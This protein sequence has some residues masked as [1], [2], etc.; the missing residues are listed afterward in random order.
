MDG[1]ILF[2]YKLMEGKA[3]TRNAIKLLQI[4]G[5]EDAIIEDATRLAEHFVTF[6]TW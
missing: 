6:G 4:M 2:P 5:Y 1:D 3:T